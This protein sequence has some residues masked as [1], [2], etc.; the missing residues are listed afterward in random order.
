LCIDEDYE[1]L[2]IDKNKELM[3]YRIIQE[4]L[5]NILKYA[6]AT[7]ISIDVKQKGDQLYLTIRD[8]GIGFDTH[9][10]GNGIG[11]KNINSRVNFYSGKMKLTSAPGQGCTLEVSIPN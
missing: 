5:N 4:Q 8:N 6:Q 2:L 3:L 7:E 10:Q 1:A 11:L 9:Q